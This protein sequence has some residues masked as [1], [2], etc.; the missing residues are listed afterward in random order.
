TVSAIFN[1]EN[2]L[3]SPALLPNVMTN[4]LNRPAI[5]NAKARIIAALRTA[6]MNKKN[7]DTK[8][9]NGVAIMSKLSKLKNTMNKITIKIKN[10]LLSFQLFYC[11]RLVPP[12]RFGF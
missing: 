6:G 1:L 8:S 5:I 4:H 10:K 3:S 9:D 2:N 12:Y 7:V 11:N